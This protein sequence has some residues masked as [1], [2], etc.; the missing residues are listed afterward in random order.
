MAVPKGFKP[1]DLGGE[2]HEVICN[3]SYKPITINWSV[4]QPWGR[5]ECA[6]ISLA[7]QKPGY[8]Y[9]ITWDHH[10]AARRDTIAYIGISS[11]LDTRFNDHPK[12]E[13]LLARKRKTFLSVGDVDFGR[14]TST[15]ARTKQI[16]EELEHILIWALWSDLTNDRKMFGMPG[17]GKNGG[18]AWHITNAGYRFGGRMPREIIYPWML[19][20]PGRD[21]ATKSTLAAASEAES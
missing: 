18:G 2:P 21:R 19:I 13:A 11:K 4:P 6:P 12:A 17:H 10:R 16:T 5:N 15:S 14:L 7:K 20:K 8:L 3:P 1:A 9:A